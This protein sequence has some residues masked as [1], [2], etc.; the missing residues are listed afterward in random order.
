MRGGNCESSFRSS[1]IE[2]GQISEGYASIIRLELLSRC[3]EELEIDLRTAAN[4]H[5]IFGRG[6]EAESEF[7]RRRKFPRQE[8]A[9][10]G[11]QGAAVQ[12]R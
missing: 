2:C 4:H 11:G 3:L 10:A 6:M 9:D 12:I 8:H 1:C 7:K 5:N